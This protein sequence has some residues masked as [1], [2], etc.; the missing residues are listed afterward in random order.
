MQ[1]DSE[2]NGSIRCHRRIESFHLFVFYGRWQCQ[3]SNDSKSYMYHLDQLRIHAVAV[4]AS[5]VR[6][7]SPH[8][9]MMMRV[10]VLLITARLI[11]VAGGICEIE[12]S[13]VVAA[14]RCKYP[15]HFFCKSSCDVRGS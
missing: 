10:G 6:L 12:C 5:L 11:V 3:H 7:L 15:Q 13:L 14:I 9:H 2:G 1:A 8:I 4:A